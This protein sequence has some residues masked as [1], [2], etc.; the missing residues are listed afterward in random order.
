MSFEYEYP[1]PMVTVDVLVLK[2]QDKA[3][4][5]L[6]IKRK[7]EPY[8]GGWALPGGFIDMNES[9]Q[10]AASRELY[11]E[12]GLKNYFLLPLLQAD[13]PN[14][15]PRGRTI[16]HLFGTLILP[17]SPEMKAGDDATLAEWFPIDN[18]PPLAFDHDYL[19]KRGV[20]EF[21]FQI[22]FRLALFA[23][24][25]ENFSFEEWKAY[26]D[27]LFRK[28]EVSY[29]LLQ[30]SLKLKIIRKIDENLYQRSVSVSEIDSLSFSTLVDIWLDQS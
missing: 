21:K 19:V 25:N 13:D 4:K 6:L 11:E 2:I 8:A 18:L 9:L 7:H 16:S 17:P 26:V 30:K 12:T 1:R 28:K 3:L 14:R 27:V 5:V 29:L 10:R 15:D 24:M 20:E 23:F 22:F